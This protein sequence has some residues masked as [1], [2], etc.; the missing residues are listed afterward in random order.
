M[1]N[2]LFIIFRFCVGDLN[3]QSIDI[4]NVL[5]F[6]AWLI[7]EKI[8]VFISSNHLMVTACNNNH[9]MLIIAVHENQFVWRFV[10]FYIEKG[11]RKICKI[12]E[13]W[14][15]NKL[16][17]FIFFS[18]FFS[19][20]K[21]GNVW[22]S[23]SQLIRP[24]AHLCAAHLYVLPS[25]QTLPIIVCLS[26]FSSIYLFSYSSQKFFAK[27]FLKKCALVPHTRVAISYLFPI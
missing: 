15:H 11:E 21:V 7:R 26:D 13:C 9:I 5:F 18:H 27:E 8:S 17:R 2:F 4:A 20:K 23:F 3:I 10:M 1:E 14:N 25:C 22:L 16:K 6:L 24:A 19:L 12:K